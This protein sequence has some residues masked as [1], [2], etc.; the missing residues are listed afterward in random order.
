MDAEDFIFRVERQAQLHGVTERALVIGIG[1]LLTER[2][3]Q[4]YW[5][6]QR[7]NGNATWVELKRAF[8]QRY[9]P[10]R[11]TDYEIRSKIEARKQQATEK[12]NDFCQDVEAL[13]VRLIRRMPEDELVE[14]LRRNMQMPLR[15]ALWRTET[16]TIARLL[17]YCS[18][19]ERFCNEEQQ[20][21]LR[22]PMRVSEVA[23]DEPYGQHCDP[24]MQQYDPRMQHY[25]PRMQ[26]YDPRMHQ[27]DQQELYEQQYETAVQQVAGATVED[28]ATAYVEAMQSGKVAVKRSEFLICWNCQDIGH[29]FSKCPKPQMAVF[30]FTCGLKGAIT[31]TCPKCSLNPRRDKPVAGPAR[32]SYTAQP[33]ILNRAIQPKNPAP[34]NPF[35]LPNAHKTQ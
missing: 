19:Y 8:I 11:D 6:Y 33:Q 30:C 24:R 12:F 34:G 18:E 22:R 16:P 17:Q 14:V 20:Q 32:P 9:A 7:Q 10:H 1:N 5:T 26:Q 21:M 4:W 31:L 35:L 15:K 13:A 2:A 28:G 29:L 27:Y 25:D 23:V 3:A